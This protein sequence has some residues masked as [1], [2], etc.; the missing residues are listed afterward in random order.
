VDRWSSILLMKRG[1]EVPVYEAYVKCEDSLCMENL[2][3]DN[4]IS[5]S[6][7]AYEWD[8]HLLAGFIL[9][10]CRTAHCVV[11]FCD[12][13]SVVNQPRFV[14]STAQEEGAIRRR[15]RPIKPDI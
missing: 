8:A 2:H 5:E 1:Y 14:P 15:K 12:V 7:A 9:T 6:T 10:Y 13:T 11:A 3:W 4:G